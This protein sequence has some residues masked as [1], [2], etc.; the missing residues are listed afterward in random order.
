MKNAVTYKK[1]VARLAVLVFNHKYGCWNV[2][3]RIFMW[4][5]NRFL[6]YQNKFAFNKIYLYDIKIYFHS[7]KTNSIQ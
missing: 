6:F 4:Y 2:A 1:H 7:I 3:K 5:Q